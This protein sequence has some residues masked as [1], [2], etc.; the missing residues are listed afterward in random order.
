M[1]ANTLEIISNQIWMKQNSFAIVM[2]EFKFNASL[3]QPF[4]PKLKKF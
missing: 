1:W 3:I 4:T 2:D